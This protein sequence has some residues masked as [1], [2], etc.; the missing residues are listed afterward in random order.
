MKR[1][2]I[3]LP[4]LVSVALFTACSDDTND[5]IEKENETVFSELLF[6]GTDYANGGDEIPFGWDHSSWSYGEDGL[7]E[8][9]SPKFRVNVRLF[10]DIEISDTY[11][12]ARGMYENSSSE[13]KQTEHT[14]QNVFFIDNRISEVQYS[15]LLTGSYTNSDERNYAFHYDND[16]YLVQV[17]RSS[18]AEFMI[19]RVNGN[20]SKIIAGNTT[21][22]YTYD[23]QEYIPMSDFCPYT[24]VFM[25]CPYPFVEFYEKMGKPNKNNIVKVEVLYKN[26]KEYAIH[27]MTYT[28]EF[29]KDGRIKWIS[30]TGTYYTHFQDG[31]EER[32]FKGVKTSF[33]YE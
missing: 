24:P 12:K 32:S 14:E 9:F 23:N 21:Y 1:K 28:P 11:V 10:S 17:T 16:G 19:E 13:I 30:H 20:I 31:S 18:V 26:E 6:A 5:T 15:W 3:L 25:L 33:I 29:D 4:V 2:K 8:S 7:L 22:Q 27:S